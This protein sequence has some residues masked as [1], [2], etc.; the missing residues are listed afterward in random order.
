MLSETLNVGL[1]KFG[2]VEAFA[3]SHPSVFEN[4]GIVSRNR[5]YLLSLFSNLPY[6]IIFLPRSS[7]K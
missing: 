7:P 6:M 5:A 2:R 4:T 1:S 3:G